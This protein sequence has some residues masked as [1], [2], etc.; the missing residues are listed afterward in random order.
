MADEKLAFDLKDTCQAAWSSDPQKAQRAALALQALAKFNPSEEICALCFWGGGIADLTKGKLDA[1]L[2][3]LDRSAEIFRKIN[4]EHL[5]AQTQ[6][7]KL[8][9]LAMRGRYEEAIRCGKAALKI[10]EK[11]GDELGAGKMEMNLSNIVSRRELHR[12]AEKYVLSARRRFQ[13]LNE[14]TWQTMAENGLANTYTELNDFRRAEKFYAQ[15]LESARHAK[16]AVTEAEIEASM[17]NLALFRGRFD[18]AL[19]LL[20]LSRQKYEMLEM[21]H[22]TAIAELEI[23]DIYLELNLTKEAFSIYEKVTGEL[24]ILKLQGEEARARS[25]FGRVATLLRENKTAREQLEKAGKLY[26]LEKN[27]V[28]AATVLLT[29]ANLELVQG[30]FQESLKLAQKAGRLLEK[31]ENLRHRLTVR[32]LRGEALRKLGKFAAAEDLLKKIF[33][34]SSKY[35]QAALAQAAQTSLG[36]LFAVQK[37]FKKA[38]RYF[39]KAVEMTERLRAPLPAEEFRMAFLADKLAPFEHLAIIYLATGRTQ[40]AFSMIEKARARALAETLQ[41][42]GKDQQTSNPQLTEKLET[43]REELN[44]FYSRMNRAE[45]AEIRGLQHEAQKR[46]KQIADVMRQIESTNESKSKNGE[47]PG[48]EKILDFKLLQ[49]Q[50]GRRKALIEFVKFNGTISAFVITSQKIHFVADLAE[51]AEFIDLLE[52]L[53]FQFGAVRY[54]LKNLSRY[55]DELKKRTHFYLQKLYE[56]L[57]EPLEKFVEDRDLVIVP[58]ASLYYIPFH[59]LFD[60]RKYV[61]ETREVVYTPSATV[62]QFLTAKEK[63]KLEKALLIGFADERIPFVNHE[64]E[65]LGKLFP[66]QKSFTGAQASFECYTKNAENFDILHMACHGHFRPDNPL[67]SS[68][69]LAD[70]FITVRDI[71]RQKLKADLV[72][73]SACETGLNEIFAGDEILGL[74][75]GFLSAGASSLVMSLWSVNDEAAVDLMKDFY[76]NLQRGDTVSA[77]LARAQRN[78]INRKVHP[79]FWSPFALIGR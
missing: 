10:F 4:R 16:M 6:V 53:Q 51:N 12:E 30:N 75:R 35:E 68:L 58:V 73:L 52:G 71:C 33:A 60:G 3:N 36:K 7:A 31:S 19:R 57:I 39:K 65:K 15:A 78:F 23:A 26:A 59:A 34:E 66:F 69:Q 46:E 8:I 1:A 17:G 22:Q 55:S 21:P 28:G 63:R 43:L 13:K 24:Q 41:D 38:E 70:G 29:Q 42:F 14:K 27:Q 50:L 20:E 2:E 74:A 32:W 72:T 11:H 67:F 47:K 44:W 37:D 25:H 40:K 56:K 45:N 5:A 9:A 48:G 18:Q 64:I 54:G 79:Y 61:I 77:S 62:W 76:E 49:N